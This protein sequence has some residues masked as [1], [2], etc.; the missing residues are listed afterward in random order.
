MPKETTETQ[1]LTLVQKL[2]EVYR[3]VEFVEKRG[4]N[5]A[6]H[7]SYVRASDIAHA[8]R[9][10]LQELGVYAQVNFQ[11][12]RSYTVE[13]GLDSNGRPKSPMQAVDVRADVVFFDADSAVTFSS[14]GLGSGTDAGDKAIFK[15]QTGALKYALRNAFLVPDNTDPEGDESTDRET[16]SK[17]AKA[18][19]PKA[20]IPN[21]K[22]APAKSSTTKGNA[23]KT[24]SAPSTTSGTSAA[25][26]APTGE[27]TKDEMDKY[28]ERFQTFQMEL[29]RAGLEAS[30]NPNLPINRKAL[31][32]LLATTGVGDAG[33]I[34]RT[35]WQTF[36]SVVDAAK[37]SEGGL[38]TLI[39]TI[40]EKAGI[41][42]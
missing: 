2:I 30:K 24:A 12:L 34:T 40:N 10:A 7:Y 18:S 25:K 27:V 38:K 42:Q 3:K 23:K 29:K 28:R 20:E 16:E 4:T 32:Y 9:N 6:Q 33:D 15:A 8:I 26:D 5:E 1:P 19:P 39:P 35:Q 31:A 11:V 22:A 21:A 41:T 36:F 17:P 14:S 37:A 13:R